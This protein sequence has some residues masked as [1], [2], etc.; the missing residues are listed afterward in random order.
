[1]N[2]TCCS[3]ATLA[4][5]NARLK[6]WLRASIADRLVEYLAGLAVERDGALV[7]V[8]PPSQSQM[9]KAIGT[10][11]EQVSRALT[12]LKRAG[13]VATRQRLGSTI[14]MTVSREL[15]EMAAR[16]VMNGSAS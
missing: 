2:P 16:V 11:R 1:M 9:A 13:H 12:K 10:G 5:D 6:R 7:I 14:G 3:C 8:R 4:A 15:T